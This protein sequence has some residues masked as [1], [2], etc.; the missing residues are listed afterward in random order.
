ML[1]GNLL[2]MYLNFREKWFEIATANQRKEISSNFCGLL[3]SFARSE[4]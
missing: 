2:D 3:S 4:G 1:T